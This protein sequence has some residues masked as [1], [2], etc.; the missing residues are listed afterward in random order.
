MQKHHSIPPSVPRLLHVS[1]S[2]QIGC[3][4]LPE[5]ARPARPVAA[6]VALGGKGTAVPRLAAPSKFAGRVEVVNASGAHIRWVHRSLAAAMVA[7]NIARPV[8]NNLGR[9]RSV[10]LCRPASLCAQCIGPPG[11]GRATGVRF[12]RIVRLDASA[13]RIV[14]HHPRA[15]YR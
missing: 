1:S 12:T 6:A 7:A 13:S 11:D 9:D 5:P 15:L 10:V 8:E 2:V 3:A 14:E 4:R